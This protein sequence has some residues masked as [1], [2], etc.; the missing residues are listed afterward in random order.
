MSQNSRKLYCSTNVLFKFCFNATD[1]ASVE[2]NS[3]L[4][5]QQVFL[6]WTILKKLK[7][8]ISFN[9]SLLKLLITETSK[10]A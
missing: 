9:M 3:V 4:F 2:R 5:F 7:K 10:V 8:I 6:T 1:V